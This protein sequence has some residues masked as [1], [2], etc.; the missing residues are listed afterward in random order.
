MELVAVRTLDELGRVIVPKEVRQKKG[1]GEGTA[2]EIYIN[3][4][5]IVLDTCRPAQEGGGSEA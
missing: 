1:W 3:N 4:D 5:T 2:I